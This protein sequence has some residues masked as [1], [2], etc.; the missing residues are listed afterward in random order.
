MKISDLF[1]DNEIISIF[2]FKDKPDVSR[3]LNINQ[4]REEGKII[5]EGEKI[6]VLK[7]TAKELTFLNITIG[8]LMN[9]NDSF[10]LFPFEQSKFI[11]MTK[12]K[13]G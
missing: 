1:S 13:E 2:N 11:K 4:L 10:E 5:A 8:G 9:D 6:I 3:L 12:N 7:T